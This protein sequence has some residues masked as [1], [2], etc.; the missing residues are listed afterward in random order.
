MNYSIAKV[1]KVAPMKKKDPNDFDVKKHIEK[2]MQ[3]ANNMLQKNWEKSLKAAPI[4]IKSE[5]EEP[6][7]ATHLNSK[8]PEAAGKANLGIKLRSK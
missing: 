1:Q 5:A 8:K 6:K 4:Q 2:N 3:T 7:L